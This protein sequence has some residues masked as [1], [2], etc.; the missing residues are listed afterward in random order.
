VGLVVG[1]AL[2]VGFSVGVAVGVAVGSAVAGF[3]ALADEDVLAV[4]DP[5]APNRDAVA[6][7][8]AEE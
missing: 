2:G 7:C 4:A 5:A 3:E 8:D 1:V 6:V